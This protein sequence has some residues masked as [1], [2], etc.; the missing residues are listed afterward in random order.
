MQL[1]TGNSGRLND[2]ENKTFWL[3]YTRN[4]FVNT[5]FDTSEMKQICNQMVDIYL[6]I[7]STALVTSCETFPSTSGSKYADLDTCV[8]FRTIE[9]RDWLPRISNRNI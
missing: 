6:D 4:G 2:K 8:N 5:T 3:L 1:E 7:C 9:T